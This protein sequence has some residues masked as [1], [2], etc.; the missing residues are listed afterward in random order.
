[1]EGTGA[2]TETAARM[3]MDISL[4]LQDIL[5]FLGSLLISSRGLPPPTPSHGPCISI[6]G[7]YLASTTR[8]SANTNLVVMVAVVVAVVVVVVELTLDSSSGR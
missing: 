1:M 6:L 3:D 2:R 5:G 7:T 8:T 4:P